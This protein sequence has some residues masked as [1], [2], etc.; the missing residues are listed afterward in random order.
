[1]ERPGSAAVVAV[2]ASVETV[3][4][5]ILGKLIAVHEEGI[6]ILPPSS[7]MH[8]SLQDALPFLKLAAGLA[9]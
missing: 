5:R 4:D 8:A 3:E 2:E 7:E 1:M 9:P 6:M